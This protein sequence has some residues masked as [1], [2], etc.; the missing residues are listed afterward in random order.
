MSREGSDN[1]KGGGP[2]V[3]VNGKRTDYD[4]WDAEMDPEAEKKFDDYMYAV[5]VNRLA[6]AELEKREADS[7]LTIK[8]LMEELEGLEKK[9]II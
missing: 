8:S 1:E 9:S 2:F 7:A 4:I 6:K 5:K 3:M